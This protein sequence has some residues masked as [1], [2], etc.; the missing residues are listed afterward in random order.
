[1]ATDTVTVPNLQVQGN[2]SVAGDLPTY[3]RASLSPDTNQII[4]LPFHIWRVWDA[5]GT[6]LPGTSATDDLGYITG[7]HGTA[8]SYIGTSDL[9]A[10]GS[11]TRYARCIA[12]LP[13][14][15]VTAATVSIRF[16]AG[17]ITTIADTTATLNIDVREVSRADGTVGSNLY[18]GAALDIR[19]TTFAEKQFALT[20]AAL[21]AGDI[22]DIKVTM[23]INDA[24]TGTAVIG[25]FRAAEIY[26][27]I[28][29]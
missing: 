11:T 16:S 22:L 19:S 7:T 1:M 25:A 18:T 29:G 8:G 17:C 28:K 3:P 24:A 23:I 13:P 10:A 26:T 15:Y 14:E 20:S 12:I 2:L 9:K 4:G 27:T 6:I 5:V 21:T